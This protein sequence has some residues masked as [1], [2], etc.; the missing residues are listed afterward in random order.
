[1]KLAAKPATKPVLL[2]A[3]AAAAIAL[4]TGAAAIDVKELANQSGR[5]V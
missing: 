2:A 3:N 1:V 5:Q 4:T